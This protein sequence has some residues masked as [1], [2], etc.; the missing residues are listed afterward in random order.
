M[1]PPV[2]NDSNLSFN[3]NGDWNNI[4]FLAVSAVHYMP[5]KTFLAIL[6]GATSFQSLHIPIHSHPRKTG[7]V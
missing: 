1:V 7:H 2:N 5:V 6:K 4:F 3:E